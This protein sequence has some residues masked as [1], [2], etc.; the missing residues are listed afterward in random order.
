[1]NTFGHSFRLSIWG[2]SHGPAIGVCLDGLPAGLPLA[3]RDFR[4][5]MKRRLPAIPGVT[6]RREKDVPQIMSGLFRGKTTGAPLL[7]VFPNRKQDSSDYLAQLRYPRPGHADFGAFHRFRGYN[8]WRGGG[9]F[10]GRMTVGLVAAG[11]VAKKIITPIEVRARLSE[12]GGKA[13][14]RPAVKEARLR[15]DSIGGLIACQ[16]GPMP[17]GLGEPFFDSVE[18]L[19]SHLLFAIPGVKAIEFGSGFRLGRMRGSEA[20][21]IIVDRNG[22]TLTNHNGGVIGG[23]T[24]GND[25]S[26]RI[27]VKPTPSIPRPQPTIDLLTGKR[28]IIEVKGRHDTCF[29]LRL[30]VI[31]EAAVAIVLAD[32]LLRAQ[33][34]PRVWTKENSI[35]KKR[36]TNEG[37]QSHEEKAS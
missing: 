4:A 22:K 10:S 6:A 13:D 17:I 34:I 31:V 28:K 27:A 8:D 35:K 9:A 15:K 2:E 23:L 11:V 33:R 30:P 20:N 12:A 26:L 14:F 16:A 1:M 21:D 37:I 24:N 32:L 29:A 25:L 36:G 3:I 7:L 19:I 5:D 18:S